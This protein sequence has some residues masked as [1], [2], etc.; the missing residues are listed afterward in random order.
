[1]KNP[2]LST[3]NRTACAASLLCSS[4]LRAFAADAPSA[5]E[6]SKGL[7]TSQL[8]PAKPKDAAKAAEP[9]KSGADQRTTVPKVAGLILER[10][11]HRDQKVTELTD[12]GLVLELR[13]THSPE[14]EGSILRWAGDVEVVSP[15]MLRERIRELGG[16]LK[17]ARAG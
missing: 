5:L 11:W 12:G 14:L 1:M 7:E 3:I 4:L 10:T 9:A 6:T 13:V 8:E 17:A 15:G 16:A 2:T